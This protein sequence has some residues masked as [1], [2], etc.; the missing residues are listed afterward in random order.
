VSAQLV[1]R[2]DE[3]A[4][5]RDLKEAARCLDQ[6]DIR[7]GIRLANLRRQTGGAGLVVSDDT[8]LNCDSHPYAPC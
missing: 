5:H 8:E 7:V 1:L 2:K 6:P 4:V 3:F